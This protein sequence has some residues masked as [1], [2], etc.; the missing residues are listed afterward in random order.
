MEF[1]GAGGG[2]VR[3]ALRSRGR[4]SDAAG[5]HYHSDRRRFEA[6]LAAAGG[7]HRQRRADPRGVDALPLAATV[8]RRGGDRR[9]GGAVVAGDAAAGGGMNRLEMNGRVAVVTGAAGGLGYEIA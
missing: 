7:D 6:D 9:A 4:P 8:A 5:D 3:G 1:P 2:Q